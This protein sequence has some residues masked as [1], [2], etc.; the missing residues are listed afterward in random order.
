MPLPWR[1]GPHG[2]LQVL[3]QVLWDPG[4]SD[5]SRYCHAQ[6]SDWIHKYSYM[7]KQAAPVVRIKHCKQGYHRAPGSTQVDQ[8]KQPGGLLTF[9]SS[10]DDLQLQQSRTS[11]PQPACRRTRGREEK[12]GEEVSPLC[13]C[14]HLMTASSVHSGPPCHPAAGKN[15]SE[16]KRELIFKEDGQGGC[17]AGSSYWLA[18]WPQ[19]VLPPELSFAVLVTSLLLSTVGSCPVLC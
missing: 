1:G 7:Q 11:L 17:L 15:E 5:C 10:A 12:T 16:E 9:W 18:A 8:L 2:E 13:G 19:A 14:H 6:V 4:L 3:C